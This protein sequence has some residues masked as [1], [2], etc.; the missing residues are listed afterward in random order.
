MGRAC[1]DDA[2][3]GGD[4][5]EWRVSFDELAWEENGSERDAGPSR[6]CEDVPTEW[7][8]TRG[9]VDRDGAGEGKDVAGEMS[10]GGRSG[11]GRGGRGGDSGPSPRAR[12]SAN[13]PGGVNRDS[14]RRQVR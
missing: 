7:V 12:D 3:E 13:D 6:G 9:D 14:L 8:A 11:R 10:C 2:D 1:D 4:G 5:G